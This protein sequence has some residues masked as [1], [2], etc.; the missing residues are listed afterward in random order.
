MSK[1]VEEWKDIK[2]FEGIYQVSDWGNVM[3]LNYNHTNKPR[4]LKKTLTVDGYE[5]VTL[6]NKKFQKQYKVHRLVAEAF[7]PNPENKP[8]IG[9]LKTMEN[10]LEDKTA[11]QAWNIAWMTNEENGNYGTLPKRISEIRIGENNPMYGKH[12]SEE[13][14]K[15]QEIIKKRNWIEHPEWY[16]NFKN[17]DKHPEKCKKKVNQYNLITGE[18]I[19]T[20]DS[21]ADVD[22]EL[23]IHHSNISKCCKGKCNSAGGYKWKFT[24]EVD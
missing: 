24:N 4:L 10:G 14:K 15:K 2:D 22:R 16:E 1:I 7:I 3:S 5:V 12:W 18:F 9:H 21:A 20:F 6:T 11:N 8:I 13:T 19:K 17:S 23:D